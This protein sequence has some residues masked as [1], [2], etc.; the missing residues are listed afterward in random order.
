MR[1]WKVIQALKAK[2]EW[3]ANGKENTVVRD[4]RG[5]CGLFFVR[6]FSMP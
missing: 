4:D 6:S 3:R 1:A 5:I 2:V